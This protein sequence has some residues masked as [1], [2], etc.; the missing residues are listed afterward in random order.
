MSQSLT[1]NVQTQTGNR[2]V[3]E[4][5]N[6]RIGLIQSCSASD[7]YGLEAASGVGDIHVVEHVPTLARHRLSVRRMMLI[8]QSMRNAG[9]ALINGDDALKGLVF[10]VVYYSRDTGSVLRK[11]VSCSWASGSVDVSANRIT[12]EDGTLMALDVT[13]S[14]L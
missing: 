12:M 3:I 11:Y 9:I 10:D 14:G 5:N 1:T 7:D 13:G 6:T 2:I 4:F 8:Q